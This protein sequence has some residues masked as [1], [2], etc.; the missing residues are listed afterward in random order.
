MAFLLSTSA[1][2]TTVYFSAPLCTRDWACGTTHSAITAASAQ[3]VVR[4]AMVFSFPSLRVFYMAE[5][6]FSVSY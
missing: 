1:S 6:C 4:L 3:I 2:H 5:G